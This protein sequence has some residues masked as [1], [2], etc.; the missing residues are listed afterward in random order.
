M[1]DIVAPDSAV[2]ISVISGTN[3]AG[4]QT[5][6]LSQ[7]IA[8]LLRGLP[9]VQASVIDLQDLPEGL[10][11]P[12]A[13]A[14]KPPGFAAFSDAVLRSDGLLVVTPEYNGGMPGVL[15]VFIDLLPFPVAFE[16]RPVAFVGVSSGRWGALRPV[17]QLQGVFG[18]RNAFMFPDRV[19]IPGVGGELD[20]QGAPTSPLI[21]G[22][23]NKQAADFSLFC[24]LIRPLR[25]GA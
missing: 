9:G 16:R 21:A 1:N 3:R 25:P 24:R 18:Y 6:R 8:G 22:L 13:Y 12:T 7:H 17:E 23:L 4:S 19:F 10:L 11:A 5:L 15:K 2:H 20:A 14:T